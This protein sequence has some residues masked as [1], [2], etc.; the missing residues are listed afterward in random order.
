MEKFKKLEQERYDQRALSRSAAEPNP[1]KMAAYHKPPYKLYHQ[2][3]RKTLKPNFR[4]LELA[5]GMGEHTKTLVDGS[6]TVVLMDIS[7]LSLDVVSQKFKES[8]KVITTLGDIENLPF[9]DESFD[10]VACAGSLSYG[11]N[12]KILKNVR[13]VLKDHGTF[14]CVDVLGDNPVYNLNR[15]FH[16]LR[17]NRSISVCKNTPKLETMKR[18]LCGFEITFFFFGALIFLTPILRIF[19]GEIKTLDFITA[20]DK[21]LKT[22]RSAFKFVLMAKKTD[23]NSTF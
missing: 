10:L 19:L 21:F 9:P 1:A 22:K 2:L 3:I 18:N 14:I 15:L 6:E 8:R 12:S 13:R 20:T 7:Q 17:R 16:V 11:N 5:C 23:F 4:V